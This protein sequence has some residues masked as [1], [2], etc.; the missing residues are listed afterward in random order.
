[1][2]VTTYDESLFDIPEVAEDMP[3]KKSFGQQLFEWARSVG[4]LLAMG[5]VFFFGIGGKLAN[6]ENSL[7]QNQ[8]WQQRQI[9]ADNRK[10]ELLEVIVQSQ[11]DMA[12]LVAEL[13]KSN[14][15]KRK[16]D[17]IRIRLE[18]RKRVSQSN[19]NALAPGG[20]SR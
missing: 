17:E 8:V 19:D 13:A 4:A 1:M 11:I 9:E 3:P 6:I 20:Y 12:R 5:A 15:T 2:S 10:A 7:A 16:A 14:E 18:Q